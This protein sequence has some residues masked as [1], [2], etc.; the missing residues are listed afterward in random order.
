[1]GNSGYFVFLIPG[2]RAFSMNRC[3]PMGRG[4]PQG[5]LGIQKSCPR[6]FVFW[7][8]EGW[9][10]KRPKSNESAA[11]DLKKIPG[12]ETRWKPPVAIG[13]QCPFPLLVQL[14]LQCRW[15]RGD[16]A[17]ALIE[18][19]FHPLSSLAVFAVSSLGL[20]GL[21]LIGPYSLPPLYA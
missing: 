17:A 15:R 2:Q 12:A 10:S 4:S 5:I 13:P 9:G 8:K 14:P 19:S 6:E 1:M 3:Y 18:P 7:E 16:G 21:T 11:V 20:T